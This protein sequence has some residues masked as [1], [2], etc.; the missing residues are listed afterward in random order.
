MSL[1]EDTTTYPARVTVITKML[2][3]TNKITHYNAYAVRLTH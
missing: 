3:A 2:Y 1:S